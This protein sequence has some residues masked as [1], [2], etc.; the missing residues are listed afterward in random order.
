MCT[1]QFACLL[2]KQFSLEVQFSLFYIYVLV[3]VCACMY[4]ISNLPIRTELD[5]VDLKSSPVLIVGSEIQYYEVSLF[6]DPFKACRR[7]E[8][9]A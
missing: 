8:L 4:S 3:P 5:C 6:E 1:N 9:L 7:R 2:G